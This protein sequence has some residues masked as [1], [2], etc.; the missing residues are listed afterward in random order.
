M[1][2][3]QGRTHDHEKSSENITNGDQGSKE[4][5]SEMTELPSSWFFFKACLYEVIY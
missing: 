3:E 1:E 2:L 4:G 5:F